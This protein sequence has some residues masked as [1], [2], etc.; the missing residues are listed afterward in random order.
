MPGRGSVK[1]RFSR[2]VQYGVSAPTASGM[3]RTSSSAIPSSAPTSDAQRSSTGEPISGLRRTLQWRP[4]PATHQHISKV[5]RKE[6]AAN[7]AAR[8]ALSRELQA[9]V[10]AVLDDWRVR[11][12]N[13]TAF[14][15]AFA[16]GGS[17]VIADNA[18]L[19]FSVL[20]AR[21]G[22]AIS[23]A[24]ER[25]LARGAAIGQSFSTIPGLRIDQNLIREASLS[26]LNNP[27]QKQVLSRIAAR[28]REGVKQAISDM[29]SGGVSPSVAEAQI[30]DS[31]GLTRN[32]TKQVSNFRRRVTAQRIPTGAADTPRIRAL[33]QRDVTRFSNRLASNRARQIATNEMQRALQHGEK[34]F[35]QQADATGQVDLE[36]VTKTWFT[37]NDD[38]VCPICEPLH[39]ETVPF[40][41]SWGEFAE[42]PAHVECRCFVQYKPAEGR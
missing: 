3:R 11:G 23:G 12:L 6:R 34:V 24:V 35:W 36:K 38:D 18:A 37:V 8:V 22:A 2:R 42:P 1:I 41:G 17:V 20:E 30:A 10:V 5:T 15:Q 16:T 40:D 27:N 13:R 39:G 14:G 28:S 32:Q 19:G 21:M 33:I 29:I 25:A 31:V 26:Y 9:D 7:K 4:T